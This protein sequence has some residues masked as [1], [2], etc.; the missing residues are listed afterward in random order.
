MAL[1]PQQVPSYRAGLAIT[2]RL[3]GGHGIW[4][5]WLADLLQISDLYLFGGAEKVCMVVAANPAD[6]RQAIPAFLFR[7]C[8]IGTARWVVWEVAYDFH[9]TDG[10]R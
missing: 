8:L 5:A 7:P 9:V 2:F 6:S 4:T 3:H 10:V 1:E